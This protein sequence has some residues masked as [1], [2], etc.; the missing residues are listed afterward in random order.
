MK[1]RRS[2]RWGVLMTYVPGEGFDG[3]EE[4]GDGEDG[5]VILMD[6][7]LCHYMAVK[8]MLRTDRNYD[9]QL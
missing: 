9:A 2:S 7:E 6:F 4:D 5:V 3:E 1:K 8:C